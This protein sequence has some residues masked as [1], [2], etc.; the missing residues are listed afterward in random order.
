MLLA[1]TPIGVRSVLL[2]DEVPALEAELAERFPQ[3]LRSCNDEAMASVVAAVLHSVS[4]PRE[5]HGLMLDPH[6]TP[7]QLKVWQALLA[8][9]A[10]STTTY[11]TLAR[12]LASAQ[13][14]RAVATAV[15]ANPIAVLIP[16]HRVVAADGQLT[17]FRWGLERKR[18]LLDGESGQ[19]G[20]GLGLG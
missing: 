4:H 19:T 12:T 1:A 6:G 18:R 8:I 2:G 7:F 10:G 20:L 11:G 3:A 13:S 14:T 17:G 16:C 15:G 9:P 5:P